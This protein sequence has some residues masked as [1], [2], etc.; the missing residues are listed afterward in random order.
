MFRD[1]NWLKRQTLTRLI[2]HT[3][4]GQSLDGVLATVAKDGIVVDHAKLLDGDNAHRLGGHV[5]V[6][7]ERIGF[8]QVMAP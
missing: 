4:D 3:T 2:V 1:R 6:E 7:R 8:V 5:L